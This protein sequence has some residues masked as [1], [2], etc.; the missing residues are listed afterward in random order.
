MSDNKQLYYINLSE[1][2][3]SIGKLERADNE[4]KFLESHYVFNKNSGD[5]ASEAKKRFPEIGNDGTEVVLQLGTPIT[6]VSLGK[7][8]IKS[9]DSLQ[10][11]L[12]SFSGLNAEQM[13]VV[14]MDQGSGRVFSPASSARDNLLAA[15]YDK[16]FV[17]SAL[18]EFG[19]MSIRPRRVSLRA[20]NAIGALWDYHGLTDPENATV[21]VDV[22]AQRSQYYV[23]GKNT[24]TS[25]D[26][27]DFGLD[28]ILQSVMEALGLKFAGSAAK[29]FYEGLYDFSEIA[30]K[31]VLRLNEK[32]KETIALN[33]SLNPSYLLCNGLP[34]GK[35][36]IFQK[37]AD[38]SG[39]KAIPLKVSAQFARSD[40]EKYF[41]VDR[42][43]LVRSLKPDFSSR[44][45]ELDLLQLDSNWKPLLESILNAGDAAQKIEVDKQAQQAR[46]AAEQKA[47]DEAAA[48]AKAL[49]DAEVAKTKAESE[50][51]TAKKNEEAA[52]AKADADRKAVEEAAAKKAGEEAKNAEALKLKQEKA[53]AEQD[54]KAAKAKADQEAKAAKAKAEQDAKAAKAKAEQDAKA[55]KAKAEQDAK[56]A[57]AKPAEKAAVKESTPS[58]QSQAGK[59]EEKKSK[60]GVII[61]AVVVVLLIVLGVL[62]M[63]KDKPVKVVE[64]VKKVA[65]TSTADLIKQTIVE[66]PV[67]PVE[68]AEIK[69]EINSE[70]IAETA[71]VIKRGQISVRSSIA[72]VEV[73]ID[74][75]LKG[76]CP[77]MISELPVGEYTLELRKPGY[78]PLYQKALVNAGQTTFLN[79]LELLPEAGKISIETKP[80]GVAFKVEPVGVRARA[81]DESKLSGKTP[82]TVQGLLPGV[83]RVTFSRSEGWPDY[84]KEVE[85]A[86]GKTVDVGMDYIPGKVK[87]TTNPAGATIIRDGKFWGISPLKQ[88]SVIGG[89]YAITI[90]MDAYESES[91]KLEVPPA[92]NLVKHLDLLSFDRV[93]SPSE[94]DV[95]PKLLG[96]PEIVLPADV[97]AGEI[98]NGVITVSFVVDKKGIP[99][100][101]QVVETDFAKLGR[102]SIEKLKNYMIKTVADWRFSPAQRKKQMVKTRVGIPIRFTGKKEGETVVENPLLGME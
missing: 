1:K 35:D 11:E 66:E 34:P 20:L 22:H 42:I 33:G 32:L 82:F 36:Y 72:D 92:S 7:F 3:A 9:G 99:S 94:L 90:V 89:S 41:S 31:L 83:Y 63:G 56:A 86:S 76:S 48:Q 62:F 91:F 5:V 67:A 52:K 70:P 17:Q 65:A 46:A 57:K 28:G 87:I 69:F 2:D 53:K 102:A 68:Q 97:V 77:L 6:I 88:D 58:P 37:L 10:A 49:A 30:D 84:S 80:S 21:L 93:V 81:L 61:A 96:N 45:W 51:A 24:A 78:Q 39:I 40:L 47:K 13:Q 75:Q 29:L 4:L 38:V 25:S 23:V 19:Q 27:L 55:A 15:C 59:P 26:I 43:G 50:A 101:I 8:K 98:I 54:A 64:P 85:V 14:L 60:V 79:Q 71:K 18:A 44:S 95:I 12:A 74:G 73:Y 100:E 16:T